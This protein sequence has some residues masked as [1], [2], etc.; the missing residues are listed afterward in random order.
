MNGSHC[1]IVIDVTECMPIAQ[2]VW[3]IGLCEIT[4]LESLP[5]SMQSYCCC[6]CVHFSSALN[7]GK[8]LKGKTWQTLVATLDSKSCFFTLLSSALNSINW[9]HLLISLLFGVVF[10][11]NHV[12]V[13]FYT[14]DDWHQKCGLMAKEDQQLIQN[15]NK[16]IA[17]NHNNSNVDIGSQQV[18][19]WKIKNSNRMNTT[20]L[21]IESYWIN[22][23]IFNQNILFK[24]YFTWM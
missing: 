9:S 8:H 6:L 18:S 10:T 7:W 15:N 13:V 4:T 21:S 20:S 16:T 12:L 23:L 1:W 5:H 2:R 14:T 3:I 22:D 19:Y 17:N 11:K 24:I